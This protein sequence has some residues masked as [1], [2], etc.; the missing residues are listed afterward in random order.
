[1]FVQSSGNFRSQS[2][3]DEDEFSRAVPDPNGNDDC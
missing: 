2:S 3:E 1:M